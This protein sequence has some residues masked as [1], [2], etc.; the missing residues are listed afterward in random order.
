VAAFLRQVRGRE[1]DGDAARR[2][3]EARGDQRRAHPLACLGDGLVRQSDDVEGRQT[4]RDLDLDIDGAR[5]D[6]FEC[7]CGDALNHPALI[8]GVTIT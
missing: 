2:K 6:P 3:G 7:N 1:I 4:R 5:L 8:P